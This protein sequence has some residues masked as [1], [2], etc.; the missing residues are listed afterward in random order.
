[1]MILLIQYPLS[2][3]T[4]LFAF[5]LRPNDLSCGIII[6]TILCEWPGMSELDV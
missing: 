3:W 4:L 1:M 2:M 6:M 5:M